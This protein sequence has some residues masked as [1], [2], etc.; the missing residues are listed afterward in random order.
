MIMYSFGVCSQEL[1]ITKSRFFSG[2]GQD[3]ENVLE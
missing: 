2:A 3:T 1:S